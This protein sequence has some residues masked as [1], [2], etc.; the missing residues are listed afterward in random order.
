MRAHESDE[1]DQEPERCH[2]SSRSWVALIAFACL[3][4]FVLVA[5]PSR[6]PGPET[7]YE[8]WPWV[9]G[10]LGLLGLLGGASLAPPFSPGAHPR[11]ARACAIR[12]T[13]TAAVTAL[14]VVALYHVLCFVAARHPPDCGAYYFRDWGDYALPAACFAFAA[15]WVSTGARAFEVALLGGVSLPLGHCRC[16]GAAAVA[17]HELRPAPLADLRRV[18][19]ALAV[20]HPG[21]CCGQRLVCRGA[22]GAFACT[23]SQAPRGASPGQSARDCRYRHDGGRRL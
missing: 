23:R 11:S 8:W 3:G 12:V 7:W 17:Q 14:L 19:L 21:R 4:L 1:T 9:I 5:P 22:C 6:P 20:W 18:P 16:A 2:A 13:V 15:L 10:L